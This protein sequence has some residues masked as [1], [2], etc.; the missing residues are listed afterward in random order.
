[1]SI[2]AANMDV[3]ETIDEALTIE[4]VSEAIHQFANEKSQA[5]SKQIFATLTSSQISLEA[6]V[7][8]ILL[9]NEVQREMLAVIQQEMLDELRKLLS[10][11][12]TSLEIKVS[13]VV[14]HTKAYKPMDKFKLLAEKNPALLELKKR[15]DLDIDY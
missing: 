8:T 5:G 10:N 3:K 2:N 4:R 13:E 6:N 11:K 14:G 15:F 7:I 9:N 12:L 1:M